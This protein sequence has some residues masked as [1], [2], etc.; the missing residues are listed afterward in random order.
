[1]VDLIGKYIDKYKINKFISAGTFGSVYE[2]CYKTSNEEE[3][4]VAIKIPSKEK[5]PKA[6]VLMDEYRIYKRVSNAE[7]GVANIHLVKYDMPRVK[8][9]HKSQLK[10]LKLKN[11]AIAMDLLGESLGKK[12]KQSTSKRLPL[13]TII[14]LTIQIIGIMK[15]IHSTGILHRD[16]KPDNFVTGYDNPNKI[17]CID[18]GISKKFIDESGAHIK[19]NT[20]RKFCGTARYASIAA[21]QNKEQGRKDDLEAVMYMLVY[22]YN[23]NLP[24]QNINN[25]DKTE[26]YRLIGIEKSKISEEILCKDMPRE[27]FVFLKYIKSLDFTSKPH[28]SSCITMFKKLYERLGYDDTELVW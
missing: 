28:Y 2:A 11:R 7:K 12:L 20:K 27:F 21:H 25:S 26:R 13:K 8:K 4:K 14:Q 23:G 6:S 15:H 9:I 10:N 3:V 17:F 5:D 22:L 24:W 1:M 19:M 18:F 16:I